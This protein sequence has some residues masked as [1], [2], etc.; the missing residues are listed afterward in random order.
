MTKQEYIV[1]K[2][3]PHEFEEIGKL[4]VTVY[5][6]L[7]GFP[8]PGEQP[9]YYKMLANVGEF[10]LKPETDLMVASSPENHIAGALVYFSDMRF[11]GS[12]GT[13]TLEKN[14]GGFR[15]L[16]VDPLARGTGI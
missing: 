6:Q 12:G 2:A 7:N 14:A 15:L 1:R 8:K 4:M 16:A 9:N 11:Y 10:T 13:A 3:R 5:S